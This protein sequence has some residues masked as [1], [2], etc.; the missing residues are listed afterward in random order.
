MYLFPGDGHLCPFTVSCYTDILVLYCLVNVSLHFSWACTWEW[1]SWLIG[2][3]HAK[4]QGS[5]PHLCSPF[6]YPPLWSGYLDLLPI[7]CMVVLFKKK[8]VGILYVF[9]MSPFQINLLQASFFLCMDCIFKLRMMSFDEPKFLIITDSR[10]VFFLLSGFCL[11]V[12]FGCALACGRSW[13]RNQAH[14]TAVNLSLSSDY[15]GSLPTEPL[16][17]SLVC[18]W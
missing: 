10:C 9:R 18:F 8:I 1:N 5:E 6:G 16:G 7:F 11:F 4:H 12:C 2:D 13:A 15:A 3:I 17:N 14:T